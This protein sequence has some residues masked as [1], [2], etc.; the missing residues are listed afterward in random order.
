MSLFFLVLPSFTSIDKALYLLGL[1][2]NLA[3][4]SL[5]VFDRR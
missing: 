1:S 4:R 5:T 2:H 3:I